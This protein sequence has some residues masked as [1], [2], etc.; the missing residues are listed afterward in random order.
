MA[1]T[2]GSVTNLVATSTAVTRTVNH[3]AAAGTTLLMVRISLRGASSSPTGVTVTYGGVSVPL[4]SGATATHST[5][6]AYTGIFALTAP[7]TGS[8]LAVVASWTNSANCII[9]VQDV[10][11]SNTT[12]VGGAGATGSSTA[13]AVSVSDSTSG[14]IAVDNVVA[15]SGRTLTPN[16]STAFYAQLTTSSGANDLV[17]RAGYRTSASPVSM[18]WTLDSSV[19]W[20]TAACVVRP[21]VVPV[22]SSNFFALF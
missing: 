21:S 9:T 12:P 5:S 1:V 16:G 10:S 20:A 22:A 7:T 15:N 17:T 19:N 2:F 6:R 4:V 14:A 3:T 11:G 13:A 8:S 18:A